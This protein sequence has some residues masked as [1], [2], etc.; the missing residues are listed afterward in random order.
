[1]NQN[2]LRNQILKLFPYILAAIIFFIVTAT[3]CR[4][5]LPPPEASTPTA[6]AATSLMTLTS[7]PST[8]P[9]EVPPTAQSIPTLLSKTAAEP[10]CTEIGQTKISPVDGVMLVCVPAGEFLMGAADTDPLANDDEKPQHKVYLN[11]FW[12]DR[13]EV[14]NANFT[15]CMDDGACR[16]EVFEVSAMT[17]TP[18]SV[19]PAYQDFPVLLYEPDVAAAYCRWAGRQLPTEAQWEKAARGTDGRTYPWGNEEIDCTRASYL[20]CDNTLKPYDPAGPRCGYSSFCR[21]TSVDAYLAGASPYGA[22]NMV[23]NVWEWVADWYSPTYYAVSPARN[24]TGPTAGEFGVRRGGG[25]KSL[26]SDLR[27]TSRASGGGHHYFDGQMGFRCAAKAV[28]P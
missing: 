23:G 22:L 17:Y 21:T 5:N 6:P 27:V 28:A 19:H 1:M 26:P 2:A 10:A 7:A 9:V 15:R 4:S 24:P 11:A 20:G 8:K 12:M 25:T 18:Y 14:T 13:T 3:S 16:P